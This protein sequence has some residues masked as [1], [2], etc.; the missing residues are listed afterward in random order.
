M[1]EQ[2]VAMI[3]SSAVDAEIYKAMKAGQKAVAEARK[4][5]DI[6]ELNELHDE[7][8]NQIEEANEVADHFIEKAAEGNEELEDELA[9]MMAEEEEAEAR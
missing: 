7:I 2:Q 9:A 4:N 5:V 1:L 8:E 3:E 6:D